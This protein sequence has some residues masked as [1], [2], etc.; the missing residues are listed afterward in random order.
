MTAPGGPRP[1]AGRKK[2]AT[3]KKTKE[4]IAKAEAGGAMPLDI[5][6]KQMRK[7]DALA[8]KLSKTLGAT[9]EQVQAAEALAA[10]RARDASPYLHAR[11]QSV[12]QK[13]EPFDITKLTD[14]ELNVLRTAFQRAR[15]DQPRVH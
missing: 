10:E 11:L 14:E 3:N 12:T 7:Y 13:N 6:L 2:G 5:M 1:G 4:A 9:G 15:N 8:D